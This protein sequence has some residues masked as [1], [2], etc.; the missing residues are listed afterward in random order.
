MK[1]VA[2]LIMVTVMGVLLAGGVA[3]AAI[4]TGTNGPDIIKGTDGPDILN[5]KGGKD[6]IAGR[7]GPDVING[8]PGSDTLFG[9]NDDRIPTD[10]DGDL[11]NGEG[12]NDV[13]FASSGPDTLVG[14]PGSDT[15]FHG[16]STNDKSTDLLVGGNGNDFFSSEDKFNVRDVVRCGN[17]RDVV[18]ADNS[19]SVSADCEEV[20]VVDLSG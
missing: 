14:G 11:I 7:R 19:D 4:K 13:L 3:F 12:G 5:G 1:R 20:N 17:G 2:L 6:R 8:G 10:R 16:V 15:L 9:S 18:F